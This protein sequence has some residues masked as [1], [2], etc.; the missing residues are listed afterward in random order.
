M[1]TDKAVQRLKLLVPFIAVAAGACSDP[2]GPRPWPATPDTVTMYSASRAEYVGYRSALDIV[3]FPVATLPIE[4]PGLTG[5]W[6]V[7]LAD[8]G[9]GL[10]LVP[11]VAFDGFSRSRIAIMPAGTDF[12]ELQRAPSDTAA[13]TAEAVQLQPNRVYVIR[14]RRA[15]CTFSSA[16]YRYAKV[17]PVT[18]DAN[19]G[20]LR[21]AIVTNPNCDNRSFVP[22]ES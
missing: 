8:D 4:A 3:S 12:D 5:N 14:S 20:S 19:A 21:F 13:Y 1:T 17:V 18:I 22:P 10:A 7:A 15:Q 2:F 9:A 11:A 6:D 16:G